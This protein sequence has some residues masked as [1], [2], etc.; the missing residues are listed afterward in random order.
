LQ[1]E[2][3]PLHREGCALPAKEPRRRL[4][5]EKRWRKRKDGTFLENPAPK[6]NLVEAHQ[7]RSSLQ[8]KGRQPTTEQEKLKRFQGYLPN[9]GSGGARP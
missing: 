9:E 7:K 3:T 5:A 2:L 4:P 8:E 1:A 6:I